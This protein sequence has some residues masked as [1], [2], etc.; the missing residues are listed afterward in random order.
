MLV[1]EIS[2]VHG[3]FQQGKKTIFLDGSSAQF[4]VCSYP[5]MERRPHAW[6]SPNLAL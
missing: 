3:G 4:P 1:V 2:V 5:M 6:D